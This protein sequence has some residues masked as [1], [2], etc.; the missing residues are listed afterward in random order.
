MKFPSNKKLSVEQFGMEHGDL[1]S[2]ILPGRQKLYS[3]SEILGRDF[4]HCQY[5]KE[6]KN[7]KY[8]V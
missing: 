8:L 3:H 7:G 5:D 4:T 2:K 1:G 6:D